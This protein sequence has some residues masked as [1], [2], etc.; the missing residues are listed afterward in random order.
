M[1]NSTHFSEMHNNDTYSSNIANV[2]VIFE[3]NDTDVALTRDEDLAKVEIVMQSVIFFLAVVGNGTVLVSLIL[4]RKSLTRMYLLMLH[5]SI[6]DLFV[7]FG[8]VLPQ[9]AWDITFVFKGGDILC[10]LVKFMQVT[11]C[12]FKLFILLFISSYAK[13]YWNYWSC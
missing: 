6:A 9:L 2:T 11:L 8:S 7:A 12:L 3:S 10:R 13:C 1:E 5:L 4:K